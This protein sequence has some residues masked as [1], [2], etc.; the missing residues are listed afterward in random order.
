MA[1]PTPFSKMVNCK[2]ATVVY[3]MSIIMHGYHVYKENVY[4]S[5]VHANIV[6]KLENFSDAIAAMVA[7]K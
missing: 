4:I 6:K 2:N 3:D 1:L 5:Q 7:K